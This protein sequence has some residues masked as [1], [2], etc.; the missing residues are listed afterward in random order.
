MRIALTVLLFYFHLISN[1]VYSQIVSLLSEN[2]NSG[3]PTGWTRINNDGLTPAASVS[4]VT[5]AWVNMED[6]DSTAMGDSVAVATSYYSPAGTADD[7]M[8][9]P[10]ITLKARGNFLSWQVK[11]KDPSWPDGY[12]VFVSNTLPAIDSFYNGDTLFFTDFEYSDWTNRTKSLDSFANQTVYIAFHAK[13]NDQFL[14][15]IDN[16]EI[17]SDTLLGVND[18]NIDYSSQI[19]PNPFSNQV[20]INSN[21]KIISYSIANVAGSFLESK[22]I[23]Q[24]R[25]FINTEN[26]SRGIYFLN[27][28]YENGIQKSFKLLKN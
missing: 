11:S 9:T 4:F 12:D 26:Y 18:A 16:I 23:H 1:C 14:L 5:N 6:P 17:Y 28:T 2:F 24:K 8:I 27:L 25:F 7:W 13:S 21:S 22:Y 19:F 10:P 15:L 3:F 20:N